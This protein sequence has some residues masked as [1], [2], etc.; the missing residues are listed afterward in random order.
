MDGLCMHSLLA[1]DQHPETQLGRS[2]EGKRDE[3]DDW[4]L[5]KKVVMM[6]MNSHASK[7]F[8]LL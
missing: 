1:D 8:F 7:K 4:G 5:Q 3:E 2:M 6:K